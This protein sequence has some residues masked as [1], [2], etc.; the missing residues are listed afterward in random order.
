VTSSVGEERGVLL[1]AP[2]FFCC[3][4]PTVLISP[5]SGVIGAPGSRLPG[6]V[7]GVGHRRERCGVTPFGFTQNKLQGTIVEG[8]REPVPLTTS[9]E[10]YL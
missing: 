7:R 1:K 3:T 4:L 10:A 6:D 9:A 2:R 8:G 5:P